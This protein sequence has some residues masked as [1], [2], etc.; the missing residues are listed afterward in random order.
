MFEIG[1]H[2]SDVS[3]F[4]KQDSEIDKIARERSTSVYLVQKVISMLPHVL[5]DNMCSL[6]PNQDRLTF[7]VILKINSAGNILR[8][9]FGRTIINSAAKLSYENV[10]NL[11]ENK[12]TNLPV[13]RDEFKIESLKQSILNLDKIAK[14]LRKK[15]FNNGGLSSN[16]KKLFFSINKETLIPSSISIDVQ[17]DSNQLVEEFMLLANLLVARHIH[18]KFPNF[19]VLKCHKGPHKLKIKKF[20]DSIKQLG[21][22]CDISS[23]SSIQVNKFLILSQDCKS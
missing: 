8:K 16:K 13:L 15:R 17:K 9:W 5:C 6:V 12:T 22:E 1:V 19:A 14:I 21:Y 7:S 18:D 11:I 4:V 10:Q 20:C 2:I 3:F 23:S